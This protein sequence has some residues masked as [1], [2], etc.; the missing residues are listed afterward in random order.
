MYFYNQEKMYTM[1]LEFK[2]LNTNVTLL[3]KIRILNKEV[4]PIVMNGQE[5]WTLDK[6]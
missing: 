3:A 6:V 4:F 1:P 2:M 5:S